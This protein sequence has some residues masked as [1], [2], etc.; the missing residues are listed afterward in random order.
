MSNIFNKSS[1]LMK[2]IYNL[3]NMSL[4]VLNDSSLFSNSLFFNIRSKA[5]SAVFGILLVETH[6]DIVPLG[7]SNFSP[8]SVCV[9]PYSLQTCLTK[10]SS[11][12]KTPF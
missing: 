1:F 11:K 9:I 4:N 5:N 7:I 3:I 12:T 6:L 8:N 2:N 10:F